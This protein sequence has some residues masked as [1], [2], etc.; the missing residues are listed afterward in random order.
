MPKAKLYVKKLVKLRLI[1]LVLDIMHWTIYVNME[2]IHVRWILLL[3]KNDYILIINT[4]I[5]YFDYK[6]F[7]VIMIYVDNLVILVVILGFILR[8]GMVEI[9]AREGLEV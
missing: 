1:I 7:D 5:R 6:Y 9:G 8:I 3:P 2:Y 4:L